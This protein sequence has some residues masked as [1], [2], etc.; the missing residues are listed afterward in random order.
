[1][2]STKRAHCCCWPVFPGFLRQHDYSFQLLNYTFV[3]CCQYM[4]FLWLIRNGYK[5]D[6]SCTHPE[7]IKYITIP[8]QQSCFISQ[9]YCRTIRAWNL[10]CLKKSFAKHF[11]RRSKTE[12][13][14]DKVCTVTCFGGLFPDTLDEV[15]TLNCGTVKERLNKFWQTQIFNLTMMDYL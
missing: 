10:H 7:H 1:M 14:L 9:N 8:N 11:E 4:Y 12:H 13:L 5:M 15:T 3:T 6:G 2:C